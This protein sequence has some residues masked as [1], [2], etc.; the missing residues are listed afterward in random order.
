MDNN[1]N[2]DTINNNTTD[3]NNINSNET[4]INNNTI[5][6]TPIETS[7]VEQVQAPTETPTAEPINNIE[8][9][10]E[11]PVVSTSTEKDKDERKKRNIL[12]YII[13]FIIIVIII[14]LLLHYC[15]TPSTKH[16]VSLSETETTTEVTSTTIGA[17]STETT[18]TE[19]IPEAQTET[20][21]T[22]KETEPKYTYNYYDNASTAGIVISQEVGV[23][24][25]S[26]GT[27]VTNYWLYRHG[28]TSSADIVGYAAKSCAVVTNGTVAFASHPSLDFVVDS[29]TTN[30]YYTAT[31]S[32]SCS[33]STS[34]CS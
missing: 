29:D 20:T 24:N 16:M 4:N 7:S 21:T 22:I 9:K 10:V 8:N 27:K 25:A 19:N 6:S 1:I 30:T 3:T 17:V 14:L 32:S 23:C 33:I 26:T 28:S 34:I 2:N 18:T 15:G 12:L 31:Y 13:M 5:A 11:E